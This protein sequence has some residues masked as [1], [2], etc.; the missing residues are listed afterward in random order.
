M[1]SYFG[2]E[3]ELQFGGKDMYRIVTESNRTVTESSMQ[4]S[5]NSCICLTVSHFVLPETK[6]VCTYLIVFKHC[7]NSDHM[8]KIPHQVWKKNLGKVSFS[9]YVF[10][11]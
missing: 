9:D 6:T 2:Y 4:N 11:K 7:N 5:R 8:R 3:I 10:S 1:E